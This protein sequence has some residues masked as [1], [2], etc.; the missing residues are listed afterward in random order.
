MAAIA[1]LSVVVR[2]LIGPI[3]ADDAYIT[4]RY[5]A[6]LAESGA[7][8]YNANALVLGTT[9]PLLTLLLAGAAWLG[10]SPPVAAFAISV[11]ADASAIVLIGLVFRR[12]PWPAAGVAAGALVAVG[13]AT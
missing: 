1:G 2:L 5:S 10:M 8:V 6:H 4:F 3:P 11:V 7:F 12:T 9:T 13:P